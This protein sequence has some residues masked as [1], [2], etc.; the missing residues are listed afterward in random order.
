MTL[1]FA[2]KVLSVGAS[3]LDGFDLSRPPVR[4]DNRQ[5]QSEGPC[6]RELELHGLRH[7]HRARL[8]EPRRDGSGL[9]G[10]RG[11]GKE[12]ERGSAASDS[13]FG[14]DLGSVASTVP[15]RGLGDSL[16]KTGLAAAHFLS[17]FSRSVWA[18]SRK[19]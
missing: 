10:G 8:H 9:R 15:Y 14:P 17:A 11:G 3:R 16:N 18:I 4:D 6:P 7:E 1:L 12:A 13:A 19:S 2:A 5:D